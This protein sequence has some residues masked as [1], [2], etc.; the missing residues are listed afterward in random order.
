MNTLALGSFA[1]SPI[2]IYVFYRKEQKNELFR[3]F[4]QNIENGKRVMRE[5]T[6]YS[7]KSENRTTIYYLFPSFV[8]FLPNIM[9]MKKG[10]TPK[11]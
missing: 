6:A 11:I 9:D 8:N 4:F 3:N 2:G 1:H 10:S 5:D 7:L